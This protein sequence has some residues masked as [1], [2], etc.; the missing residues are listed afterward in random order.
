MARPF[1]KSHLCFDSIDRESG[2]VESS[3]MLSMR[4]WRHE[5]RETETPDARSAEGAESGGR[6]LREGRG[7][8][9]VD[10][11]TFTP[12]IPGTGAI[13]AWFTRMLFRHRHDKL[14]AMFA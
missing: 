13:L 10:R 11:I 12:R 1:S 6:G 9:L 2:F 7:S 3:T 8:R 4:L 5:R 14:R